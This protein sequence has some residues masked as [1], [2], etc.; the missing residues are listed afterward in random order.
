MIRLMDMAVGAGALAL[1]VLAGGG[2]A[3]AA[4]CVAGFL[5]GQDALNSGWA[6]DTPGLCRQILPGDLPAPSASL[7]SGS[8][9]V[10]RPEGGWPQVSPGFYATL[11]YQGASQLRLLR[12][13]PN[14][15]L[16]VAASASGEILVLRPSGQCRLATGARFAGGLDRPFGMAFYPPGPNP[17]YLYVA[18]AS[19]I[20]RYP[21]ASGMLAATTP[22]ETMVD[23]TTSAHSG[24]GHST[25]DL[26][27]SN[28]GRAMFVS[29]GSYSN[30]QAAGE[31]ETGRAMILAFD[32]GGGDRRVI[33]WGMRNPVSL[34]VAPSNGGLWATV[35]ERDLLGDNL[36][37]D[38]VAGMAGGEFFGWPWYYLGGQPDPAH[39]GKVPA[40]L[41]PVGTPQLL[42]QAH[43]A[44]LGSA[45]YTGS[46]FPPE[47][48]NNLFVALHGS[49]NRAD[50]I[51]SKVVRLVFDP[52][53][54]I[55]PYV[56]DFMT[57]FTVAN[58][59]VWGRPVGLAVGGDGM[60]YVSEDANNTVWCV[61]HQ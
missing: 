40:G 4:S 48:R 28:D 8:R 61:S 55:Q 39:V 30:N 38:Y 25:R 31:D 42:F 51:G 10:P 11:F 59:D 24:E 13:A 27:F 49:W 9:V 37:P 26:V 12:T 47:Y 6:Q 7:V 58:H 60:L 20:V 57:G 1:S 34:S 32:P 52:L 36:V 22:P 54:N 33:A 23:L 17:S 43:S 53:G 5:S 21:Y 46:Q 41:P 2:P 19:R 15:D 18:E 44:P 16:F 14:G 50:P 29:I 3:P 45:F 35:N 56:E